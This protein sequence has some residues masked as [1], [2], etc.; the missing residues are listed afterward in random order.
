MNRTLP[1]QAERWDASPLLIAA[2]AW[3][4]PRLQLW[5]RHKRWEG[6]IGRWYRSK[7]GFSAGAFGAAVSQF[8][9]SDR[10]SLLFVGQ[11]CGFFCESNLRPSMCC[12]AC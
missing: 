2:S 11:T 1:R 12:A 9:T 8:G 4:R 3:I 7:A 5:L 10:R 6:S